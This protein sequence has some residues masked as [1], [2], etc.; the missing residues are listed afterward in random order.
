MAP[1]SN[2]NASSERLELVRGEQERRGEPGVVPRFDAGG[3][4]AQVV[5]RQRVDDGERLG[6]GATCVGEPRGARPCDRRDVRGRRA[7]NPT[8]T[9]D[10]SRLPKMPR[11][12]RSSAATASGMCMR[13]IV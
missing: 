6:D 12:S 10:C 2:G 9:S 1:N 4:R 13:L 5:G 11:R 7:R 3:A 8:T